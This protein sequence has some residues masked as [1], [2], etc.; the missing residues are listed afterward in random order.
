[1]LSHL[2]FFHLIFL[3]TLLCGT[4]CFLAACRWRKLS[5]LAILLFLGMALLF[6]HQ[7]RWQI[8]GNGSTA[9]LNFRRSY[10]TRDATTEA[11]T[12]VRGRLVDRHGA[13]LA[14][15]RPGKRWEQN[16]PLGAAG[17]HVVGYLSR[18][19]GNSGLLRVYDR[20]LSGMSGEANLSL[21]R[22]IAQDI[23]T[24]L[25]S[26]LQRTAYKAL[27][28][29]K[30]AVVAMHPHTGEILAL[31]S[32]PSVHPDA[33]QLKTAQVDTTQAPLF[34]RATQG[35]YPPGSIFKIFTAA[36]ALEHLPT[37]KYICPARGWVPGMY[38][39][40]IR[41]SHPMGEDAIG[42]YKAFAESSNIW[43]AK[44]AQAIGAPPFL[45]Q[46][47]ALGLTDAFTLA[48]HTNRSMGTATARF[49]DYSD[50]P[51]RLAYLGFGQGD[52][53]VTPIHMA[54]L[55]AAVANGGT[56][57]T[58]TLI[59]RD[60]PSTH[61][62]LWSRE[63]ADQLKALMRASVLEG[64]S[65][66]LKSFKPPAAG[67][68]GTAENEGSDHAWFTCFAPLDN[69]Q[70]VITVLVENGGFGAATALPIAHT[71]LRE[72]RLTD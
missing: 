29:R 57:V 18:D 45:A 39:K 12:Q 61:T 40:P 20:Q 10:D 28:G 65:K 52:L 67:K 55:T 51:N 36:L 19:F 64:T 59:K 7:T 56:C 22:P 13:V 49:P 26:R 11:L 14:E 24:T 66:N 63:R 15:A 69:P 23:Q 70:I 72:A 25:D 37:T 16:M 1:M 6:I 48:Q 53:R 42:I 43:F 54:V 33:E 62:Q 27:A 38:T 3:I 30:G 50:T 5:G 21:A 9:F 58:P 71:L 68:T 31:V 46:A 2:S 44:A 8:H 17:L 4:F 32:S 34:N 35:L 41:D 60:T 47:R